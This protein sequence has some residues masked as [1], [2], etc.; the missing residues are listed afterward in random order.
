MVSGDGWYILPQFRQ[1]Q[2]PIQHYSSVQWPNQGLP[3]ET[4]WNLWQSMLNKCFPS[5]TDGR[6]KEPLGNWESVDEQWGSFFE[7]SNRSWYVYHDSQWYRFVA[8]TATFT[9]HNT[10]YI[11]VDHHSP[12]LPT[13]H[14]AVAWIRGNELFTHSISIFE[15]VL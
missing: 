13:S 1:R 14:V 12:K 9:G 5:G 10:R 15:M 4:A 8:S 3:S 11:L 6:L 7:K 2:N